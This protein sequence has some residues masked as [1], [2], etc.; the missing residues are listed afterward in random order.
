M[1]RLRTAVC[2]LA[3]TAL[4]AV[5]AALPAQAPPP[6]PFGERV[7]VNIVNVEVWV[8]DKDG[9]PVNGL[10]R[11]DFEVR[12][13]GKPLPV[14]NFEAF[15]KKEAA[16]AAQPSTPDAE[17]RKAGA[18]PEAMHLVIYVDNTFLLPAHRNRVL[19]QLR[20]FVGRLPPESEVM[21]ATEDP[22][23]KIRQAFTRDRAALLRAVEA[24]ET[25]GALGVSHGSAKAQA[26]DTILNIREVNAKLDP[27]PPDLV[28]PARSYA[29]ELRADVL[30]SLGAM[31]VLVNSL[32]G[33]PGR[34]ALLLVS[35]G[36]P[37][38]PGE[39]I[40][41][42]LVELCNSNGTS[43]FGDAGQGGPLSGG[44]YD[45]S[46]AALDAQSYD[47]TNAFRAFTGHA[48]AQRVTVYT[49]EAAGLAGASSAAADIGPRERVLQLPGIQQVETS[50]L[51]NSLFVLASDT[52]GRAILNAND[53][54]PS[55]AHIQ[56][57]FASYYSLAY[58]PPHTGDGHDHRIEVR[59]K[60]P[61]TKVRSRQS[62]RDKP[63]L[64]RTVDR[65]LASLLYGY[66]DNPL[67]VQVEIGASA[68]L[69]KAGWS[70]PIR[71]RIPLFHVTML[72]TETSFEGRLRVLVAT[73]DDAG[74]RSPVR[75]VQVPISIPRLSALTALGQYY[76][77][78][79][80]LT[81]G[82]GEQHVAIAVRDEATTTT[83]FIARTLKP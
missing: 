35:D 68:P 13:D 6:S 70:V 25:S 33:I 19:R 12:E 38:T 24:I 23:L 37:V 39:E 10:Q 47:T 57:D 22:A 58:S 64:E 56:E 28:Q 1:Q 67:E 29:D 66:E 32:S 18:A 36:M 45:A 40:F 2:A 51:Q 26:I 27:C 30:R 17:P 71:L 53:L 16:P 82:A 77:Y 52:G 63:P 72:P 78:E 43:G 31:T 46:Q 75:Q 60:R 41:Q 74:K 76:Q 42:T 61:G 44:H 69:G 21:L 4:T 55:L 50:N 34:K 54:A 5:A 9:N 3:F 81:L 7:D 20:D 48:N 8:T 49:L 14:V 79:V 83:S 73:G 62:Y 59:V 80:K 15:T 11:S 65:T